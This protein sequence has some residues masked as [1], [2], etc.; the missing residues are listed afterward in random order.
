MASSLTLACRSFR[1]ILA[2]LDKKAFTNLLGM[3]LANN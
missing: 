2:S 1:N 3:T